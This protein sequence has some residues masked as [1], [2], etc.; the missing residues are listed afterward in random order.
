M[1]LSSSEHQY[2]AFE[3]AAW[4]RAAPHYAEDF[5]GVT[6]PFAAPVLDAVDCAAG[7]RLLE[8]ACG[9]G[10]IAAM[11]GARGAD[12]VGVDFSQAMLH[13]ALA[14][15]PG[16]NL[17]RA[18]AGRLPIRNGACDAVVIGFG[19]QHFPA[20]ESAI[21]EAGRVLRP[22]GRLA[23]TSWSGEDNQF[24]QV[25]LDAMADGGVATASLPSAP[26]GELNRPERCLALLPSGDYVPA[27]ARVSRLK[28]SIRVASAERLFEIT[29]R[30]T[31]R[32]AAAIR[33]AGAG[34]RP[35]VLE[36]LRVALVPYRVEDGTGYDVPAVALLTVATRR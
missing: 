4:E 25:L 35:A 20:P 13:E 12:A 24:Q 7:V 6:R 2:R 15:Y 8:V 16:L 9:T 17:I 11:A 30:S 29:A 36:A 33:A 31:A 26:H 10:R 28:A 21:A 23:F 14:R 32:G 34:T 3:H 19:V 27:S 1:S 22:G 18:D 5:G